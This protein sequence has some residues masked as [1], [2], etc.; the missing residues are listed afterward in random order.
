MTL[1]FNAAAVRR[2]LEHSDA[3]R[4]H[5][6]D[7]QNVPQRGVMVVGDHG[8]YIMSTGI[9]GIKST[10]EIGNIK[11]GEQYLVAYA[12]EADPNTVPGHDAVRRSIFDADDSPV[13]LPRDE[14]VSWLAKA[15]AGVVSMELSADEFQ[16][17]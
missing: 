15:T 4:E 16:L 7:Q 6:R 11:E 1:H 8:I 12:T 13:F 10:G 17:S 2:L 3:A 5:R 14:M 9:P